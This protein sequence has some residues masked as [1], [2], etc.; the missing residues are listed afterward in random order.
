MAIRILRPKVGMIAV[1]P[2]E[3]YTGV[4]ARYA[5]EI[6]TALREEENALIQ[7]KVQAF[8]EGNL[9]FKDLEKFIRERMGK[10]KP[11]S[12]RYVSL[13][14][15]LFS[16]R[17]TDIRL[18]VTRKKNDLYERYGSG[19]I[20]NE[21]ALRIARELLSVAR[22]KNAEK[23][24]PET[25]GT[26]LGDIAEIEGR[27]TTAGEAA[28][29]ESAEVL[30]SKIEQ[31]NDLY[32]A[33]RITGDEVV[34]AKLDY[35]ND[36]TRMNALSADDR[37]EIFR[38]Q[39][40][41][42]SRKRGEILDIEVPDT[43]AGAT[44]GTKMF[45]PATLEGIKNRFAIV[46]T[47]EGEFR[48]KDVISNTWATEEKFTSSKEAQKAV[49]TAGS[50]QVYRISTP[51]GIE[52]YT[53]DPATGMF[54]TTR[55]TV[56]RKPGVGGLMETEEGVMTLYTP[57]PITTPPKT[58]RGLGIE[59]PLGVK[60]PT[61]ITPISEL[62]AVKGR[63]APTAE[64]IEAE[65]K[66]TQALT[67]AEVSPVAVAPGMKK[68]AKEEKWKI[69]PTGELEVGGKQLTPTAGQPYRPWYAGI[70]EWWRRKTRG[71]FGGGGW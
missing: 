56:T 71:L 55:K 6:R 67:K 44:L 30:R 70:G 50:E 65:I 48:V 69:G 15:V 28:K 41:Q 7:R 23:Y 42:A 25:W 61:P 21:E 58:G 9:S 39:Q 24:D 3:E 43:R 62:P 10:Y 52:E 57:N 33:G 49:A 22:S 53:F 20:T 45:V 29:G 19:G 5:S 40:E 46:Q 68:I 64:E 54:V 11:D 26:I 8:E 51:R 47:E 2:Q 31:T 66:R 18:T 4:V 13:Q 60:V 63:A 12:S 32:A 36:L 16:A 1:E 14:E 38:L 27:I 34:A 35:Y 37:T 17:T 59:P